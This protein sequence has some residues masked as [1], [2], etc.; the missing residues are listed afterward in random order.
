MTDNS[1]DCLTQIENSFLERGEKKMLLLFKTNQHNYHL[2]ASIFI[3]LCDE[4]F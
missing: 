4:N 2:I 3:F 1:F